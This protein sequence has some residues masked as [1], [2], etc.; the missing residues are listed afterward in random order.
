MPPLPTTWDERI[1]NDLV[2]VIGS[3]KAAQLARKFANDL[4][5][6]FADSA[7]S[8]KLRIEA[9]NTAASAG[10]LGFTDLSGCARALELA[11]EDVS[12]VSE[13]TQKVRTSRERVSQMIIKKIGG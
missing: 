3:E 1:Y 4:K 8:E 2:T 12:D 9:H 11:C 6:R 13:L 10:L 7:N 5:Q